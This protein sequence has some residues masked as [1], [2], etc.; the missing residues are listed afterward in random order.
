MSARTADR[1]R[2]LLD[3]RA[4][5]GI[6]ISVALLWWAFHEED[7]AAIWAELKLAD[8]LLFILAAAAATGVFWIRAWRWKG[9]LAA[10]APDTPFRSRFAAVS[11]GFMGNNLLPLRVGE[12]ARVYA[13]SRMERVS[14]VASFGSLVIERL[15]DGIFVVLLLFVAVSL[16]GFPLVESNTYLAVARGLGVMITLAI[17]ILGLLVWQPVRSVRLFQRIV[18]K[19]LPEKLER[20]LIDALESFLAGVGAL[21][22]PW[23]VLRTSAWSLVLWLFNALGFYIGLLAFGMRLPFEA[24]LFLQ[25]AVALAVSIPSGPGFFGP[26]EGAT[27][28]VLVGIF[29]ADRAQALA[30]AI[31]FHLAGFIPITLIGLFYA[32]RLGLSLREV[33]ETEEVVEEQVEEE[34]G[35]EPAHGEQQ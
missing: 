35:I 25:S 20:P 10:A 5:I 26:F 8:P 28:L 11:I 33:A 32:W 1:R 29:G 4:L 30:Y 7:P 23:L 3:W 12:F 21:R 22:N 18:A 19:L 31:G 24:A 16:P 9:I 14:M 6:G 15:F 13:L 17:V 34:T 2:P 27:R